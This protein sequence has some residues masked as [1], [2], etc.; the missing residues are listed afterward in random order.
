MSSTL[1]QGVGYDCL[2]GYCHQQQHVY[3]LLPPNKKN[4]KA[5]PP[6]T[7]IPKHLNDPTS[8]EQQQ[9]KTQ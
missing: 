4:K 5:L 3:K 1:L 2:E 9:Q 7:D 6:A 8:L